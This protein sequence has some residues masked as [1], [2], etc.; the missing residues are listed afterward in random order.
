ME[1]NSATVQ[2]PLVVASRVLH[3]R[4]LHPEVTDKE[5]WM[6]G[7]PFGQVPT[8]LHVQYSAV[9]YST[10]TL[11]IHVHDNICTCTCIWFP[12]GHVNMYTCTCT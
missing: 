4:N 12:T 7:T 2:V 10:C 11:Y 3:V 8:Y 6:L 9:Q 1:E 5:V